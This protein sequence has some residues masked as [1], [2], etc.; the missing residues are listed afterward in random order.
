MHYSKEM[1]TEKMTLAQYREKITPVHCSCGFKNLHL[2]PFVMYPHSGGI[3]VK[4]RTYRQWVYIVCP[5]CGYQWAYWK[6]LRRHKF[7][8][9][10]EEQSTSVQNNS[11]KKKRTDSSGFPF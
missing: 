7:Y 2:L 1:Q 11:S 4:N 9:T 8:K 5:Q 10:Q 3:A 6:L